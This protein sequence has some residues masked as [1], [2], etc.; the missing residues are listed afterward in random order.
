MSR[1]P[2]QKHAAKTS[3]ENYLIIKVDES[4]VTDGTT[5]TQ[6]RIYVT[7][8][9]LVFCLNEARRRFEYAIS[10]LVEYDADQHAIKPIH[11]DGVT[12]TMD[13]PYRHEIIGAMWDAIDWLERARK[14]LGSISGIPKKDTRYKDLMKALS[15]ASDWRDMLQHYDRD[16]VPVLVEKNFPLMGT[17]LAAFSRDGL[18]YGRV[19]LSTP[20]R[21]TGDQII[22]IAGANAILATAS[23]QVD[24]V[25]L[26]VANAVMN[27]SG[28]FRTLEGSIGGFR[29]LITEK[30]KFDWA[31]VDIAFP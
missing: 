5:K 19:I 12:I 27:L 3:A 14:I 6:K 20:A 23:E 25:T 31:S 2:K 10:R 30:F 24:N 17:V 16:V 29:A 18:T 1:K 11:Q 26:S 9:S 13:C 22:S 21:F 8:N 28:V 4:G 15:P 7:V